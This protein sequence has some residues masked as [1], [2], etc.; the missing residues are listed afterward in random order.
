VVFFYYEKGGEVMRNNPDDLAN[1]LVNKIKAWLED[2]V[3]SYKKL[4]DSIDNGE[5]AEDVCD[6]PEVLFGRNECAEGLLNQI[7]TWENE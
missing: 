2:E 4:Q 1:Q 3:N 5:K 7:K 6:Q